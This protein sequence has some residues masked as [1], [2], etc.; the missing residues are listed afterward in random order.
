M[1]ANRDFVAQLRAS[2]EQALQS[3]KDPA[4]GKGL[5]DARLAS[6]LVVKEDGRVAFMIEV[7]PDQRDRGEA[8]RTAAEAAV[9]PPPAPDRAGTSPASAAPATTATTDA[10]PLTMLERSFARWPQPD[11]RP[12]GTPC[13]AIAQVGED[14]DATRRRRTAL[15]VTFARATTISTP[16]RI[17]ICRIER[18]SDT[19]EIAQT[20]YRSERPTT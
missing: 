1:D 5:I 4:S 9:A 19:A 6:G 18:F 3:V 2:V 14:A 16:W 10:S 11:I 7:P 8:L 13:P 20:A 17:A 15:V 12:Y